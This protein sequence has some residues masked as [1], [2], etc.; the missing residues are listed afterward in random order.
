MLPS[1][2]DVAF[3]EKVD[4]GL[5]TGTYC[6]LAVSKCV[7]EG[8]PG[9]TAF[10]E[11]DRNGQTHVNIRPGMEIR[12][13]YTIKDAT[14][15]GETGTFFTSLIFYSFFSQNKNYWTKKSFRVKLFKKRFDLKYR[16]T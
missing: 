8:C 5:S 11:V 2:K 6:N 16:K 9:C 14:I 12:H 3:D 10:L 4:T 13:L 15:A 7:V 1:D